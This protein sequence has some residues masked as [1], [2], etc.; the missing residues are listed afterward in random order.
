M[1]K[2]VPGVVVV[3]SLHYDIMVAAPHRPA[4]GE[5]VQGERWHPKFGGKGGNQAVAAAK[6]GVPVRMLGAVGD[7]AFGA[8][9]RENLRQGGVDD[10]HVTTLPCLASGMSVAISDATGDYGAV[11]VSGANLEIDPA[12]LEDD[13]LWAGVAMLVLQNEVTEGLN[14][15]AALAAQARGVQVCLNAAPYRPLSPDLAAAIDILVVNALEAE[16]LSGIAVGDIRGAGDAAHKL[17]QTFPMAVVTAGG[18]GV[19]VAEQDGE[20]LTLPAEKVTLV[21]THGAGDVFTGAL[22][23]AL[24][25]GVSL[26]EAARTA[27][28]T[29]ARHVAGLT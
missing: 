24:V 20:S 13:D 15:A 9:L 11:I 16:A 4:A 14:L 17:C 6:A 22:A 19:A 2:P 3:G 18:D 25:S 27:N 1:S 7:D 21:S 10:A 29:A 8:F 26:A 12:R 5:T 28:W 23:A